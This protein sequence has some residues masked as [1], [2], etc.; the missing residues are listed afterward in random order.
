M[1]YRWIDVSTCE[2]E[3]YYL[4]TKSSIKIDAMVFKV[5]TG[6]RGFTAFGRTFYSI[7]G[8]ATKGTAMRNCEKLIR[9]ELRSLLEELTPE[10][11]SIQ[12][13]NEENPYLSTVEK[14]KAM[15]K[16]M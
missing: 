2:Q 1:D 11:E 6:G 12:V 8:L 16:K 10:E 9:S 14:L 7:S 3:K 5:S 13:D 4:Y 15:F